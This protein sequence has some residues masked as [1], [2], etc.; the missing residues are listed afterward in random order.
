MMHFDLLVLGSGPAGQKAAVQAAKLGK[1]AAVVER[2]AQLGGVSI[3]AGTIPSK[4]LREAVI[5]LTGY[6]Q[7]TFYGHSYTVDEDITM[8][9]L[10]LRAEHV[11]QHQ[12]EVTSEQLLR[13]GVEVLSG[14][15]A[16]VDPHTIAVTEASGSRVLVSA[17]KILI[18]TGS[19]AA[20]DPHI[21]FD[22]PTSSD[23]R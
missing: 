21:P 23:E 18:A 15:A 5:Y 7:R 3:H 9:D 2:I 6:H 20:R 17:D 12:I 11:I 19:E 14:E 4:T 1:R 13:N 8:R 10:M 16:F 22:G